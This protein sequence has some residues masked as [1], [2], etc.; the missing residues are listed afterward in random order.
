MIDMI[1]AIAPVNI[2]LWKRRQLYVIIE[3][4]VRG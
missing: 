2:R 1:E 4:N 3:E